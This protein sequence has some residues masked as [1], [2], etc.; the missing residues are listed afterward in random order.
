[1][2]VR[3]GANDDNDTYILN[4]ETNNAD[5]R[6]EVGVEAY[7]TNVLPWKQIMTWAAFLRRSQ[8]H[9][10][11]LRSTFESLSVADRPWYISGNVQEVS[12]DA[13]FGY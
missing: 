3:L 13:R 2:M 6:D 5:P 4:D 9:K 12:T 8:A 1:M 10:K 7:R 11:T